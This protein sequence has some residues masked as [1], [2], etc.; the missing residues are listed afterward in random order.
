MPI[1]G[2]AMYEENRKPL[3]PGDTLQVFAAVFAEIKQHGDLSGPLPVE[4]GHVLFRARPELQE[5]LVRI[6]RRLLLPGSGIVGLEKLE[7]LVRRAASGA[8]CLLCL[9][10]RSN[11]DVPTLRALL[12]DYQRP[13]LFHKIFW[14]AGRKLHEDEGLT[15][16]LVQGFNRVIVTPRS[17]TR[18]SHTAGELQEAQLINR[19][20]HRVMH[21]GRKNGWV[22]A[23]FPAGTRARPGDASTQRAI[24]ETDSY[25]KSF[26]FLLPGHIAGCTLP[27]SRD[28]DLTHEVPQ[29]DRMVYSF[30]NI[31]STETW[32]AK[33]ASR[34]PELE[35]REASARAIMQ[36]IHRLGR[37]MLVPPSPL[38]PGSPT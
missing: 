22:F 24:P 34:F 1:A 33:A 19:A 31:Q 16:L 17:W 37:Q 14:V 38:P 12:D 21:Q 9:N 29:L 30:G 13:E 6:S 25:L 10:H 27:V 4:P 35:Q 3:P 7:E 20:A 26:D 28:R 5:Y 18:G 8:A 36:D 32:R 11:L 2:T 15:G 23:L